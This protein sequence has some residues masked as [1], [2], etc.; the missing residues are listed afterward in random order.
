MY[1]SLD[2]VDEVIEYPGR[3]V[4]VQYDDRNAAEIEAKPHLSTIFALA[5]IL[6]PR[7]FS[8]GDREPSVRMSFTSQP[9]A[10]LV[11]VITAAEGSL[12]VVG[13]RPEVAIGSAGRTAPV[14]EL[15]NNAFAALADGL[16]LREFLTLTTEGLE[17][18]EDRAW[19][20]DL[21]K[22]E[23]TAWWTKTTELA[24]FCGEVIRREL[25][26]RWVLASERTAAVPFVV[27]VRD[28]QFDPHALAE[29]FMVEG[30]AKSLL[31]LLA[32]AREEATASAGTFRLTLVPPDWPRRDEMFCEPVV[33]D[34]KSPLVVVGV[35]TAD[36][37]APFRRSAAA[38]L[39]DLQ[40]QALEALSGRDA[41]VEDLQVAGL[42]FL[43][44]Q[45]NQY[46]AEKL[47]DQQFLR[48]LHDRLGAE[49]LMCAVPARGLL[50]VASSG[51]AEQLDLFA[52]AAR[53]RFA[54]AGDSALSRDIIRVVDGVPVEIL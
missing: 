14:E 8:A 45:G 23:E 52:A 32:R 10:F 50:M 46:A 29:A 34:P 7:L 48:T 6:V 24:A 41:M 18:F 15:A 33:D 53:Q 36:G 12:E 3:K 54:A 25:G 39:A 5:R 47:L 13:G 2:S 42:T 1:S 35:D 26:G 31:R 30:S 21:T 44:V 16:A 11:Q 22:D 27:A 40:E 38:G 17:Q 37:F 43:V 4:I 28:L 19:A 9:P 49:V 51:R 20:E